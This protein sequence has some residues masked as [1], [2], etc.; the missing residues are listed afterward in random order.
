MGTKTK[1]RHA[2]KSGTRGDRKAIIAF[3]TFCV[4]LAFLGGAS[5]PDEVANAL[6]RPLGIGLGAV[7]LWFWPVDRIDRG[8]P[9]LAGLLGFGVICAVQLVPL[10]PAIWSSLPGREVI[11]ALDSI[12]LEQEVWRP[13][14]VSPG[15]TWNTLFNLCALAG[16]FL[17]FIALG[18]R[19]DDLALHMLLAIAI[20]SVLLALI[21]AQTGTGILPLYGKTS[22]GPTGL[23]SNANHFGIF[24]G[25]GM[26]IAA[27]LAQ[28]GRLFGPRQARW[29]I[30]A[31][32]AVLMLAG[33]LISSSRLAFGAAT[34]A[35]A[36]SAMVF[37]RDV[38]LF[39]ALRTQETRRG[40]T[41]AR[42][43]AAG[44]IFI[45][46]IV[47][48]VGFFIY[49]S[50][51]RRQAGMGNFEELGLAEN[52]RFRIT[53]VLLEIASQQWLF[54]LG[55]GS[56]AD[57][58]ATVEP[59]G[60]M[61]PQYVNH[62]HNDFLQIPIEGGI[63]A[64]SIAVALLVWL[65]WRLIALFRA[66]DITTGV[67]VTGMIG[68]IGLGSAFDYVLRTPLMAFAIACLVSIWTARVH[69]QKH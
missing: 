9:I 64:V 8:L 6:L 19:R 13:L 4:A 59:A 51:L 28:R 56:F 50:L 38:S 18:R 45:V 30:F 11:V 24:C 12:L 67:L 63:V 39:K 29:F 15:G 31:T 44:A 69:E 48:L 25:I 21:Q 26:L 22:N 2:Q 65:G 27:D 57:F 14:T 43:K 36:C 52:L 40:L 53:P 41:L 55:F 35:G 3:V 49:F 23:F 58:Y 20:A 60:T 37:A 66:G 1:A 17:T 61:G 16:G 68:I 5:R 47:A 33:A 7:I 34:L 42:K 32:I 54:G 46:L 10:P 62:A